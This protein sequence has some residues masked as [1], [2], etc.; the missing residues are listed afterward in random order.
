MA[1]RIHG[2]DSRRLSKQLTAEEVARRSPDIL[3]RREVGSIEYITPI[4]AQP[5]FAP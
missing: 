3:T 5:T 1:I 4:S 2:T